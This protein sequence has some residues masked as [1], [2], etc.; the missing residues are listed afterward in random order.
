MCSWE[1]RARVL[2][3]G[4]TRGRYI[5]V[6][7]APSLPR[8]DGEHLFSNSLHLLIPGEHRRA[9]PFTPTPGSNP[10]AAVSHRVLL[11]QEY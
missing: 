3:R 6:S 5:R 9:S 1:G 4:L 8:E 11:S 7:H 2:P 10:I